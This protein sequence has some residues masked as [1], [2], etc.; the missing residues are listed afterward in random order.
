MCARRRWARRPGILSGLLVVIMTAG[1]AADPG[2][3]ASRQERRP[4]SG[5]TGIGAGADRD[6]AAPALIAQ[7]LAAARRGDQ[8]G[9]TRALRA[10]ATLEPREDAPAELAELAAEARRFA[11]M[12]G[13]LRVSATRTSGRIRVGLQDP[14]AMVDRVEAW[15][16]DGAG[17]AG[18]LA[19]AEGE[20]PGR[21]EFLLEGARAGE[22]TVT[23]AAFAD[24]LGLAGPVAAVRLEAEAIDM[25]APPS[26]AAP[27]PGASR[28][29]PESERGPVAW[30]VVALGVLAAGLAGVAVVREFER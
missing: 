9:A 26:R 10:W 1:A 27:T 2:A 30:W 20:A 22:R 8:A 24:A 14:A 19:R 25:P 3:P 4:G 16:A 23:V 28:E 13:P 11:S 17:G 18:R 5:E 6:G 15:V 12:H 7:A 21:F 29:A